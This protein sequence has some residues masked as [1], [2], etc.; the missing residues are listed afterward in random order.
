MHMISFRMGKKMP[1]EDDVAIMQL[2][3]KREF[4]VTELAEAM[5]VRTETVVMTIKRMVQEG[6]LEMCPEQTSKRGRPKQIVSVTM[7]GED[8]LRAYEKL[9]LKPLRSNR[10]DLLRAK[11]DA[12]YTKR[13]VESGKDPYQAFEELNTIVRTLKNSK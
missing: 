11:E 7:L 5:A 4:G 1:L 10:N 12:Q 13:L 3:K 6:L 9:K 8:F 2:A